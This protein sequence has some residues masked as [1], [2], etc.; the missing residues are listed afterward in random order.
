ME[1]LATDTHPPG[2]LNVITGLHSTDK[3]NADES[4]KIEREHYGRIL[5]WMANKRKQD[6]EQECGIDD[7]NQEKHQAGRKFKKKAIMIPNWSKHESYVSNN[8]EIMISHIS[9]QD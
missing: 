2:L 1:P 3:V 7:F 5:I 9:S 8:I 6:T 4:I